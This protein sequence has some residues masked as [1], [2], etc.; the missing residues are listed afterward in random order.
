MKAESQIEE[1]ISVLWLIA[2][3]LAIIAECPKWV[4]IVLF[5]KFGLDTLCSIK[6]ALR[7]LKEKADK[8]KRN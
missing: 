5:I 2:A 6:C 1:I 7:F 8:A 3:L 4:V